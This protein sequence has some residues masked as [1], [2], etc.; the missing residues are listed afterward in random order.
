[1]SEDNII[2]RC[3]EVTEGEIREAIQNGCRSITEIKL[4]T[5]AGMGICQGLTCTRL[6]ER[7]LCEVQGI[8]P[9]EL[10]K[11]YIRQPLRPVSLNSLVR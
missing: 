7:I 8:S 4:W 9:M 2:C 5:R 10:E 3:E 6:A 1:M 11:R